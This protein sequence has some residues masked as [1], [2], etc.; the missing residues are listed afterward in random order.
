M[1]SENQP[2]LD[3]IKGV[4]RLYFMW[5][6]ISMSE[7]SNITELA[8]LIDEI[9]EH[10]DSTPEDVV[11]TIM[12][13][14]HTLIEGCESPFSSGWNSTGNYKRYDVSTD[15]VLKAYQGMIELVVAEYK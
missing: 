7:L 13:R 15:R 2:L 8:I 12:E 11:E 14:G 9:C 1:R 4:D 6:N 10:I 5:Y 3:A